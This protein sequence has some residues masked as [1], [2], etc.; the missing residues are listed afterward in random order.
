MCIFLNIPAIPGPGLEV[1]FILIIL[2][3]PTFFIWRWLLKKIIKRYRTRIITTWIVTIIFTPII[4]IRLILLVLF[5]MEYYPNR[6]FDMNEW[7]A[8]KEHRYE[9]S[10][11]IISS[12]MLIG[13]TKN[14]I[15]KIL[16]DEGNLDSSDDWYYN[17]GYRP[18]LLNIDPDSMHINFKHGKVVEVFQNKR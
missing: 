14:E 16:G 10:K 9:Y 18:Q 3:V 5:G 4:Y 12:K 13:K 1:Y 8:N 6:D 17:L 2:A 11:D 15:R 7:L